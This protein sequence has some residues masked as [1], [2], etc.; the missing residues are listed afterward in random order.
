[1]VQEPAQE[2]RPA[3]PAR[4]GRDAHAGILPA[5]RGCRACGWSKAT[6][7]ITSALDAIGTTHV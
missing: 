7:N 4:E 6:I 5:R 1:V 3:H 2:A